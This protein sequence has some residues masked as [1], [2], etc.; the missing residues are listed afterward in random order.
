[1]A[2]HVFYFELQ[3]VLRPALSTLERTFSIPPLQSV[4][5]PL[6]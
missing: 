2:S 6:L 3:L 1:M 4:L 5:L